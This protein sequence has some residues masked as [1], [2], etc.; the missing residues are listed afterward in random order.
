MTASRTI[1]IR[2][3]VAE[4]D[5]FKQAFAQAGAAGHAAMATIAKA[6][7]ATTTAQHANTQAGQLQNYQ[8]IEL[9]ESAHKFAD[10]IL[11]GGSALKAFAYEAPNFVA[12]AG[13]FSNALGAVG[14]ALPL[15]AIGAAVVGIYELGKSADE[16]QSRLRL[17]G[18]QVRATR[19]DYDAY[20]VTLD[21]T[22]RALAQHTSLSTKDARETVNTIG[23]NANFSG[24]SSDITRLA[25]DAE[26]LSVVLKTDLAGGTK[27]I[28]DGLNDAAKAA[29][30]LGD[31]GF[32]GFTPEMVRSIGLL[33][34]GGK[35]AEAFSLFLKTVEARSSGAAEAGL[36]PLGAAL[37][38]LDEAFNGSRD[39]AKSF[40]EDV[41]G[42]ID[43]MVT[44]GITN[45]SRLIETLH[46]IP[47]NIEKA[48]QDTAQF[49]VDPNTLVMT[50]IPGAPKQNQSSTSAGNAVDQSKYDSMRDRLAKEYGVDPDVIA[51]LNRTEGSRDANGN[52]RT[53][54]SGAIG[55]FQLLPGTF[56][57]EQQ[58]YGFQG[59]INDDESNARAG[60]LYYRDQLERR[61][62][63]CHSGLL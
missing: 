26:N 5:Q 52:W 49:T 57:Q 39:G 36:T 60:I 37:K 11:A 44:R 62:G 14:K 19:D 21:K 22:A 20:A 6:T 59:G 53:S 18:Q 50:P 55:G 28:T 47:T 17:L 9:A 45:L 29:K 46:N 41:G 61:G 42:F 54:S 51:R 8:L 12:I 43:A 34:Q 4:A 32:A 38:R 23:T 25:T 31:K 15:L 1:S 13:G 2:L 35:Y 16:Q 10:G 63:E 27:I 30:D 48:G 58:K 24:N 3:T 7:A 33:Q 56:A 40:S